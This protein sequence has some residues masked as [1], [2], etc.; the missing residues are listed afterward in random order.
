MLVTGE[1]FNLARI[2][3]FRPHARG[4]RNAHEFRRACIVPTF[5]EHQ[6]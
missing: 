5:Q 1:P 3:P 6:Q 4:L 2:L